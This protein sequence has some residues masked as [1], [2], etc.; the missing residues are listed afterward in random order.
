FGVM[1]D[2]RNL[3]VSPTVV[4]ELLHTYSSY[5]PPLILSVGPDNDS[6]L[7]EPFEVGATPTPTS[8]TP[9]P[10]PWGNLARPK[11]FE[12][13]VNPGSS[14]L[15]DNLTNHMQGLGN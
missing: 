9:T 14:P 5:A 1:S 8:T 13:V 6:G 12:S 3:L 15:A 2:P 10:T 11:D 4:E 7:G